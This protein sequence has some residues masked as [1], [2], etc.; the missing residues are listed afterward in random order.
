MSLT[1]EDRDLILG[2]LAIVAAVV[3]VPLGLPAAAAATFIGG[4][5]VRSPIDA[6]RSKRDPRVSLDPAGPPS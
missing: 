1:P 6:I 5:L 2:V 4:V 3:L